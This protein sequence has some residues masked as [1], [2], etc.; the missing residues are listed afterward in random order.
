[1]SKCSTAMKYEILQGEN[2]IT[3]VQLQQ[4][5][6]LLQTNSLF[7]RM[8]YSSVGDKIPSY[9]ASKITSNITPS[10]NYYNR[11][12]DTSYCYHTMTCILYYLHVEKDLMI[13]AI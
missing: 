2:G 7:Q 4:Q 10:V 8:R 1:M 3:F 12:E 5:A 6:Q 9:C 13:F 11:N